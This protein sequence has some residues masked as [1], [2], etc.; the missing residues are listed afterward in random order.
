LAQGQEVA[1]AAN[2]RMMLSEGYQIEFENT[3]LSVTPLKSAMDQSLEVPRSKSA[4][5][6]VQFTSQTRQEIV[7]SLPVL[8]QVQSLNALLQCK[9]Q[10]ALKAKLASCFTSVLHSCKAERLAHPHVELPHGC[11][12]ECSDGSSSHKVCAFH[13]DDQ[14]TVHPTS[15]RLHTRQDANSHSPD[16]CKTSLK[17]M[18]QECAPLPPCLFVSDTTRRLWQFF[19][20][21]EHLDMEQ[22]EVGITTA[23]LQNIPYKYK[24]TELAEELDALGMMA[25][26]DFLY[27]PVR[28]RS[29][30]ERNLGYAFV[31]CRST[32]LFDQFAQ[33]LHR[34]RFAHYSSARSPPAKVSRASLQGLAANLRSLV[35]QCKSDAPPPGLIL[36]NFNAA[37]G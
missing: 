12:S 13:R 3:F 36:F 21:G 33:A 20:E 18:K 25:T 1:D 2:R 35:R 22:D 30:A 15:K 7:Q 8:L 32:Q 9:S 6:R 31:N 24:E 23:M 28:G 11:D 10:A 16:T 5:A 26:Y 29:H 37:A 17:W 19:R 27:L 14:S 34:H 4:S